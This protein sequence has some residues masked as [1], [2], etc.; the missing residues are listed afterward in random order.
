MARGLVPNAAAVAVLDAVSAAMA[1]LDVAE[2][3][4]YKA[5]LTPS[6]DT[7]LADLTAIECDY[8]GYMAVA[9][10][11]WAVAGLDSSGIP[12]VEANHILFVASGVL[13]SNTV[14]GSYL[15]TPMHAALLMVTP[16]DVP[17]I[18]GVN[19]LQNLVIETVFP[20]GQVGVPL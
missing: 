14:Y 7:V 11:A 4:L 5:P 20:F 3:H 8:T 10:T 9:I 1:L 17:T 15:T 2:V 19:L 13:V 6:P 18:L 16:L 12:T